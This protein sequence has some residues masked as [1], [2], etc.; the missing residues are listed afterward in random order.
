MKLLLTNSTDLNTVQ[1]S[2]FKMYTIE[3]LLICLWVGTH[4]QSGSGSKTDASVITRSALNPTLKQR[5]RDERR[6]E[7]EEEDGLFK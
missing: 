6:R 1:E 4:N 5:E 2:R 3:S 7:E